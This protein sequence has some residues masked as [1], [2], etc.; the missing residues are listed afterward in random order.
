CF[1]TFHATAGGEDLFVIQSTSFPANDH[2]MEL[3]V[4]CDA[5]KRGS[6]RRITAVIP[7][8]GYARQD[9]KSGPP[10]L[11]SAKLVGNL[12]TIAG[13]ARVLTLGRNAGQIQGLFDLRTDIRCSAPGSP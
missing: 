8:Y 5:L 11:I 12:I 1:V 13:A 6:A 7:Y 2:L 3:L 9:R 10:T 4:S